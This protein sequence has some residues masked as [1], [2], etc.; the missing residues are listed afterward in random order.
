MKR[1]GLFQFSAIL[2]VSILVSLTSFAQQPCDFWYVTPTGSSTLGTSDN[3]ASLQQA[4][5]GITATRNHVRL[6]GGTYTFNSKITLVNDVILEGGYQVN[7]GEWELSSTAS[8]VFNI[9]PTLETAIANATQVGYYVGVEASGLSGFELRN[10]EVNVLLAGAGGMT[11]NLGQSIYGLYLDGCSNYNISRVEVNTGNASA[12]LAGDDG[13]DGADGGNASVGSQGSCDGCFWPWCS[14][15]GVPGGAGGIGGGGTAAGVDGSGTNGGGGGNGG[16]G[17]PEGNN[18]GGAGQ[19]GGGVAGSTANTTGGGNGGGGGDPGGDGTAGANGSNGAN[20]GNGTTVPNGSV[21]QGLFVPGGQAQNGSNG[22][23]GKGGRGGGGGGGQGCFFC[24]NGSGNGGGGGGGG[25]AAGEGGT[26]GYGGGA[27]YGLFTWNNG[28]GAAMQYY[29]LAPGNAGQGGSGGDGGDG[30]DGGNGASGASNCS[31]EIGEGASGG[32]G[33]D[34]GDG[35]DAANGDTG[36]STPLFQ[37][38]TSVNLTGTGIPTNFS[39]I[40]VNQS[41]GCTN[42]EIMLSKNGGTFNPGS[43]GSPTLVN[44]VDPTTTSYVT[45]QNNISVYY[46]TLGTYNVVVDGEVYS[47]FISIN[48]T[49]TLPTMN[50]TSNGGAA[51]VLCGNSTIDMSTPDVGVDYDWAI[52]NQGIAQSPDGGNGSMSSTH[53]FPTDGTYHVRLRVKDDCCGWSIPVY[54]EVIVAPAPVVDNVTAFQSNY[55]ISD[56]SPVSMTGSPSGGTFSGPGVSST[57]FTPSVAAVGDNEIIYTYTD[58]NGC[59][60]ETRDTIPVYGLPLVSFSGADLSYCIDNSSTIALSGSPSG[61]AFSGN[62][63]SGSDFVAANAGV[64]VASVTYTYTDGNGCTNQETQN[65]SVNDLP[66]LLIQNLPTEFCADD[67]PATFGGFPNGGT[68]TGP[69][70]S[71]TTFDPASATVGVNTV[72]YDYTDANQCSNTT[73]QDVTVHANP[74][75]S[76]SGLGIEYCEADG[77]ALLSGMPAG[78]SF[79]GS[80]V[81][82]SE[83]YP[84]VA[85]VGGPYNITY[86]Y[87]DGNGCSNTSAAASSTVLASPTV[88]VGEDTT[89]CP[90]ESVTIDAGPGFT[91]YS[92]STTES[93]QSI[94]VN[95]TGVFG[96][97]VTEAN[98]CTGY[99]EISIGVNAQLTPVITATGPT[100]VC[101]GETVVLEATPGYDTYLWSDGF[102]TTES[103]TVTSSGDFSVTVGDALGCEGSS[104]IVPVN[105]HPLPN[106]VVNPAGP[107]DICEGESI[108][109]NATAGYASY[110]WNGMAG[111]ETQLVDQTGVYTVEI[112]SAAGCVNTSN[113][114][115]VT[116][117][118]NPTATI[119]ASG[120]LSFCV[121]GNVV[122]DAGAGFSSYLWTSGSTTQSVTVT[123]SGEYGV[124]VL[125][126]FGCIDSSLLATPLQI[127]VWE[128]VPDVDVN[129]DTLIVAN[130]SEFSSFQWFID[131][132]PIPGA[133]GPSYVIGATGLYS[134]QVT[135][136]QNCIGTSDQQMVT[137]CVGIEEAFFNAEIDLYPN[138]STGQFT[139]AVSTKQKLELNLSIYNVLGKQVWVDALQAS[140]TS[141]KAIDLSDLPDG[142]YFLNLE[143]EGKTAVRKL[144]KQK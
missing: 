7:V 49:R 65:I 86:T 57:S 97:T 100:T 40:I 50:V 3:P 80:G 69:G 114:V 79:N 9:N 51:S 1:T 118:D 143:A 34:G 62:G 60:G 142:I 45:T 61:G 46:T 68:F 58:G 141:N 104:T 123:Q 43:M 14:P 95:N 111:T 20:G 120:P 12:G 5:N 22:I 112:T 23:A 83:F 21:S 124:T 27:A 74:S 19:T 64:G 25:G 103:L 119:T 44:D 73:T 99:D 59:V 71:G 96:V 101:Q 90:L 77:P 102:T 72:T 132:N 24:D 48:Q 15:D 18:S 122:L 107:V 66:S 41:Q 54:F 113:P 131:G 76:F 47:D 78:G 35:G 109:L 6:L 67:S 28:A 10:L 133:N 2:V 26:G 81:S 134:V 126:A 29:S 39:P 8:T 87:T 115:D 55:C 127:T 63:V 108:N 105:V 106:A 33:G 88:Y 125:D 136:P 53:T 92:W 135:D 30:G 98:G 89:I 84:D 144:V 137:C 11:N 70:V 140:G 93:T 4:L 130:A 129:G 36:D 32:S 16:H 91:S 82:G 38:G 52:V 128:P 138:P 110:S 42:S 139:L 31:S 121:G 94:T 13:D 17:G 56:A 75:A 117:H 85:G 37:N 116:V